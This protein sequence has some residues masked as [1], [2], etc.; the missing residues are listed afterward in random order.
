MIDPDDPRPVFPGAQPPAR[1]RFVDSSGVRIAVHEWGALDDPPVLLTHGGSE[2]ARSFDV[3]APLLAA[4]GWRVVAWDQ[5]GHGDSEHAPLASWDADLR[6]AIA[7]LDTL[8]DE[9]LPV[10]GHSKGGTL[11]TMLAEAVPHRVSHLVNLDGFPA[12]EAIEAR[13]GGKAPEVRLA[14]MPAWLDHRRTVDVER[15]A[16]TI[17][18]LAARRRQVNPRLS[19]EWLRYLVTVGGRRGP[20]GWRW[21]LDPLHRGG[22]LVPLRPEWGML[23]MPGLGMPF[24]AVLGLVSEEVMSTGTTAAELAPYLPPGGHVIELPDCGHFVHV[25]Q[26]HTVA[27][28]IVAFLRDN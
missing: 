6:D 4:A 1:F 20:D 18:E 8:S 17:E 23:G 3:F 2:F 26:P 22:A 19:M 13:F 28:A 7:V 16:G 10:I 14:G 27:A 24:L 15:R 9:P 12:R 11:M 5:R 25:E 21:K